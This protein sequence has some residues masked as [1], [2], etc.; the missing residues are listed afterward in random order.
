M[1]H[2]VVVES[3]EV[4]QDG[5][6][7][8]MKGLGRGPLDSALPSGIIAHLA[9]PRTH[10]GWRVVDVWE[11]EQAANA[12][13]GSST[14]QQVVGGAPVQIDVQPWPLHRIEVDQTIRIVD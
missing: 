6:D 2:A 8:L 4:D 10:G 9:G 11:S 3:A 1:A 12:F 5:Y 7:E 13:Y 14:F